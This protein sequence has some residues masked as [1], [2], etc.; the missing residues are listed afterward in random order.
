MSYDQSKIKITG[1]IEL[2]GGIIV[3]IGGRRMTS[4]QFLEQLTNALSTP[5]SGRD[6]IK[7][8][9]LTKGE[10]AL[11]KLA[12]AAQDGDQEAFEFLVERLIGKPVQQINQMNVT[13]S[14]KE[15]LGALAVECAVVE[16]TDPFE[17]VVE[18][19]NPFE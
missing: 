13:A 19:V 5:Y 2:P 6:P 15:F 4:A 16:V 1:V 8:G 17:P 12:E 9:H 3:P 18:E 11:L 10:A 14:L 7:Y